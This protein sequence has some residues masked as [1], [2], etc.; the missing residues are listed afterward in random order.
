MRREIFSTDRGWMGG[1]ISS[2]G[3]VALFLP[4]RDSSRLWKKL[5]LLEKK[6]KVPSGTELEDS[7]RGWIFSLRKDLERYWKGEKVDFSF[8]PCDWERATSFQRKVWSVVRKIPFGEVH[9]YQWVAKK[10]GNPNSYRA[11]GQALAR[12]PLLL[13]VPCHRVISSNGSL[14]GFSIGGQWKKELLLLEKASFL[15]P[16]K[17]PG[18]F[19]ISGRR[20]RKQSHG[21]P[22]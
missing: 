19:S 16:R 10:I 17:S 1:L 12:N 22:L 21:L 11:V 20:D 14:G 4:E 18:K 3:L 13:V 8:Y 15:V 9:T 2:R 7:G 5:L 6:M